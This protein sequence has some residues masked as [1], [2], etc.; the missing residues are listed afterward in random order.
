MH[1]AR[2]HLIG[3][4]IAIASTLVSSDVT[5][6]TTT[7]FDG[8]WN[9][10]LTCPPYHDDDDAKGYVHRFGAEVKDG[11]FRGTH[12][13]EGEPSWHDLSGAIAPDG[14]ALLKLDGI[15][16]NPD[17]SVNN[18]YRGKPYSYRVR[19]AFESRSGVGQRVGK[20]RCDFRFQHE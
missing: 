2:I 11:F 7:P 9:V 12:G 8:K 20:R 1:L 13:T 14:T 6:E 19:A 15:V 3:F 18:A 17:Y 4:G 16:K 5:A 10:T